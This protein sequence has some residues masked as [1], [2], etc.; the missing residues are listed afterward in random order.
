MT[1]GIAPSPSLPRSAGEGAGA[2]REFC[3]GVAAVPSPSIGPAF[4]RPRAG[5]G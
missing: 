1:R 2:L 4:G 5:E 3:K